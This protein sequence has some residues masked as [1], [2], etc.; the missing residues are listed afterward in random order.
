MTSRTR[1]VRRAVGLLCLTGAV[2]VT[3]FA[4]GA[5]QAQGGP[6]PA[7]LAEQGW[8]C[9][10]PTPVPAIGTACFN[11]GEGRPPIPPVEGGRPSYTGWLWTPAGE[12][13]GHSHLIRA[14][15][16]A[17]QPCAGTGEPYVL[18]PRLLYYECIRT[19]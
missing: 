4:A 1:K 10:H 12:F 7:Q 19:V 13:M 11:P 18:N 8:T 6:S 3:G 9:V 14:D 16:Y 15:L 5:G 17:G 2:V